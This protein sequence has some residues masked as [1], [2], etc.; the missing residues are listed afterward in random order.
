M[1][2][3]PGDPAGPTEEQARV[4]ATR[5][6]RTLQPLRRALNEQALR[7]STRGTSKTRR[8]TTASS[9]CFSTKLAT[10]LRRPPARSLSPSRNTR[11]AAAAPRILP[12]KAAKGAA[13]QWPLRFSTHPAGESA[14]RRAY[15]WTLGR[16]RKRKKYSLA[17]FLQLFF[18][19]RAKTGQTMVKYN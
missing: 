8:S 9:L 4:V 3:R 15:S 16:A 17:F 10:H 11:L 7:G 14:R 6:T 18:D 12:S 2:S 5:S 19:N 1:H 13:S